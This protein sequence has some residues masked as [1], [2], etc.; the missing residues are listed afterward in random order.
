LGVD[1]EWDYE[2]NRKEGLKQDQII[3]LGTD[4]IW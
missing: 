3:V 2:T 1:G 4:G